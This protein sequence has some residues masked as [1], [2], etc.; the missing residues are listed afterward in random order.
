MT[1][2][3]QGIRRTGLV[4]HVYPRPFL[5]LLNGLFGLMK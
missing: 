3:P 5:C 4:C 2:R 1:V